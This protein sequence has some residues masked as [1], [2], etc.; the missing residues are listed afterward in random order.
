[1]P[2]WGL[3]MY[4]YGVCVCMCPHF[5]YSVILFILVH[6]CNIEIYV[7]R[8]VPT[9]DT[10]YPFFTWHY[11]YVCAICMP[12]LFIITNTY[13]QETIKYLFWLSHLLLIYEY[14]IIV[15]SQLYYLN[16]IHF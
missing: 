9:A 12:F 13:I 5:F 16:Y 2:K 7:F 14:T 4:T 8:I 11:E 10:V 15:K 1:M 6:L 3:L